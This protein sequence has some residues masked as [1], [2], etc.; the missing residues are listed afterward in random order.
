MKRQTAMALAAVFAMS[1]AGTALAAPANPF[2]DVPAKHWSYD[3]VTKLAQAGVISGYG[4]GTF[5]GDR[6][7]TRYEMATIV[8]KAMANADKADAEAQ[9]TIEALKAEYGTELSNLGVRVDNLEKNASKVK[10][11]GEIR[12]RFEYTDT[13]Q[14]ITTKRS[15]EKTR[16]RLSMTAPIDENVT[17]KGRFH[18]ESQF[19]NSD[20][21]NN[22]V[23]DQAYITGK[24]GDVNYNFGRQPMIFGNKLLNGNSQNN[25]GLTLSTGKDIRVT[26][27][28]FKYSTFNMVMGHADF[29]LNKALH[30]TVSHMSDDG[31]GVTANQY[32]DNSAGFVYT[33][34]KNLTINGEYAE[35][36]SDFAKSVNGNEKSKAWASRVKYL[37]ATPSK[38]GTY[39]I[40]VSYRHAEPGFDNNNI[41]DFTDGADWP[42]SKIK[43]MYDTKGF[44]YG[45]E[46]T[47]F[48]NGILHLQYNDLKDEKTGTQDKS[49]FLAE[50]TYTF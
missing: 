6:T 37:G 18:S 25:D 19:G 4:D 10:F 30:L 14:A 5:K 35:N 42:T 3:A 11:T 24:L 16:F 15:V 26:A 20:S 31:D 22:A 17:F 44:D 45:F 13:D 23:L 12:E 41:Q 49:N 2:A 34:L 40:A 38:V 32:D 21:G 7:L 48:K 50:L 1:V 36:A 33:G 29:K 28:A 46:Y 8:A 39:G 9:K 27:G 47:I 43:E